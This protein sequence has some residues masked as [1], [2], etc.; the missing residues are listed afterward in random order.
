[1]NKERTAVFIG[2]SNCPL[3]SE[4]IIPYIEQAILNGVDTFLNGGQGSF[5]YACACAV[6]KL[7][8]KYSKIKS[9]LV[10]P[11]HNF[12]IR[13]NTLFDDIINANTSNSNSYTGYKTAIPKRNRYMVENSSTAICYVNHISG[14]AYKTY[15]LAQKKKL[16][17]INISDE[18]KKLDY[19]RKEI[20][21]EKLFTVTTELMVL[22]CLC[23]EPSCSYEIAKF[24]E[25]HSQ[26]AAVSQNAVF[27]ALFTLCE[28]GYVKSEKNITENGRTRE[29]YSILPE[30]KKYYESF[31][32]EYQ[33][34]I[35]GVN[36][37]LSSVSCF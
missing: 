20:M 36:S 12:R 25:Q 22:A 13:D 11:Y 33:N 10:I 6:C 30:G 37:V 4:D 9:I 23:V 32:A 34:H 3:S 15:Q 29:I 17:I 24:I 26:Q 28:K 16:R 1:M 19:E 5:D 21:Q 7:K 31:L 35:S 27:T 8:D 14:G 18:L 2:H